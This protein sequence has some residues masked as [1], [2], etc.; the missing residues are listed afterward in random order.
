MDE[1]YNLKISKSH[2]KELNEK[3]KIIIANAKK[4]KRIKE[5]LFE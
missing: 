5:K 2:L 3:L 4:E 1:N